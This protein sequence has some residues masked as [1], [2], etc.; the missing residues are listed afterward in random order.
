MPNR[1]NAERLVSS[2]PTNKA[3]GAID[4]DTITAYGGEVP[5][6]SNLKGLC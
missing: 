5:S 2:S 6:R 1:D 3:V 4:K